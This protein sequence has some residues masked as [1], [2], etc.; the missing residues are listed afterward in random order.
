M[1]PT[2]HDWTKPYYTVEMMASLLGISQGQVKR[3]ARNGE[4]PHNR[5]GKTPI[6][7]RQKVLDWIESFA[8]TTEQ[9]KLKKVA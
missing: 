9:E 2:T 1:K 8:S 7:P 5:P 3:K 6:F 4:I